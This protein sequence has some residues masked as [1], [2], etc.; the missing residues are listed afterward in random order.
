MKWFQNEVKNAARNNHINRDDFQQ[1]FETEEV[2]N[3]ILAACMLVNFFT[4]YC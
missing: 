2:S 4:V 1:M 3:Y